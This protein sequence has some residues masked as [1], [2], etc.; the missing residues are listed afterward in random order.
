[1]SRL[2]AAGVTGKGQAQYGVACWQVPAD[3]AVEA[4]AH[5]RDVV[6]AVRV[7]GADAAVVAPGVPA[8]GVAGGL[9]F[10]AR[11]EPGRAG[12]GFSPKEEL[13]EP[14]AFSIAC[15]ESAGPRGLGHRGDLRPLC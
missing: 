5:R 15:R 7:Q 8:A 14:T 10:G 12:E 4:G 9:T 6:R 1:M 11:S 13:Y 2:G 3:L